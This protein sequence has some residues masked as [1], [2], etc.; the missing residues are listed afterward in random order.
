M[1]S[2]TTETVPGY[3]E[4]RVKSEIVLGE[5]NCVATRVIDAKIYS[6]EIESLDLKVIKKVISISNIDFKM[7]GS[8]RNEEY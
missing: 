2:I 1:L 4:T 3:P 8:I 7:F 6:I 5:E